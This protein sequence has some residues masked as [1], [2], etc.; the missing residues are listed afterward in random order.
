VKG[1]KVEQEVVGLDTYF[2]STLP[3]QWCRCRI[4]DDDWL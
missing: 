1:L 2:F 3:T 4:G